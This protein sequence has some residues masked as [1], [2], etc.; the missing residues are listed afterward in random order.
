MPDFPAPNRGGP[1]QAQTT[2][3][4]DGT[5][6]EGVRGWLLLLCPMLTVVGPLVSAWLAADEYLQRAPHFAHFARRP[7]RELGDFSR[8]RARMTTRV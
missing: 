7:G 2:G 5:P 3:A 4:F 6:H 1:A 8:S